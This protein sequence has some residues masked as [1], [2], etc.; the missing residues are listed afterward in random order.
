MQPS[1]IVIASAARTAVGTFN[2]AFANIPAHEL[3]A[4][5]VKGAMDRAG[6]A[7]GDKEAVLSVLAGL[8]EPGEA[9]AGTVNIVCSGDVVLRLTVDYV[10]ARLT[11]LGSAWSASMRP[12]H[13]LGRA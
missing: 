1:D 8:F 13:H 9:P 10:E 2:G 3:G 6:V 5:A 11:D 4:T 7:A 12:N